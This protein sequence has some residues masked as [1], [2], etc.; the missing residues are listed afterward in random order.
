MF[1]G[2]AVLRQFRMGVLTE[3]TYWLQVRLV[4]DG[5][6]IGQRFAVGMDRWVA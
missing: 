5:G 1:C 3:E 6:L 4:V 2:P